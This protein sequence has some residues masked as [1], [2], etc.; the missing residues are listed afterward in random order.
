MSSK[1]LT[2]RQFI[3]LAGTTGAAVVLAACAPA[4]TATP[5]PPTAAPKAQPTQAPAATQVPAT[6][7][8]EPTKA[9]PT[10]A[11]AAAKAAELSYFYGGNPQKDVQLVA[12]AMSAYMKERINATIK[13]NTIEWAAFTEKMKLKDA[14]GELYDMCFTSGWANPY[15][16]AVR[17][18]V[19]TDLTELLPKLA[20][21]YYGGLNPGVWLA[22]KVKGKIYGAVNEQILP[23]AIGPICRQDL[24]EKYKLDL[25]K[26]TKPEDLE[27]W[28]E[29]IVAGEGGK[30]VPYW[31]GYNIWWTALFGLDDPGYGLVDYND[32]DLKVW[33]SWDHAQW[34]RAMSMTKKWFGKG[35]FPKEQPP[36]GECEQAIRAGKYGWLFHRAKPGGTFEMKT[37]RGLDMVQK[38]IENPTVLTTGNITSTMTAVNKKST[39]VEACVKYFELVN[40]D[41][42]FYNIL[43][44]GIEGK[45][46]VWTN[47]AKEV[48][49]FPEGVDG[50]SSGYNP[51]TDWEFG[52]QFNAYYVNENQVGSWEETRK[53]NNGSVASVLMGFVLDR[54]P[55]K[56]ELAAIAAASK[57]FS[58]MA[59]GIQDYDK[60]EPDRI[61]KL[62]AAGAEKVQAEIT[63][64]LQA[65]KA[66]A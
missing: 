23:G 1:N 33:H 7:A 21:K 9:Q 63:K 8:P 27:A 34:K 29:A 5:V 13:L 2:R 49:G 25:S 24:V 64:Q 50:K 66:G 52:N 47:K 48:V 4:P 30:V 3:A 38:I 65:W 22:P 61:A 42:V 46:W 15:I 19:Y 20:P 35:F 18:G 17:N 41:K 44:K 36:A 11:P 10:A 62:K 53:I 39:A 58:D 55:I 28:Q 40:T 16:D 59:F 12:D 26:V 14:A 32:K 37:Q 51:N 31:C 45:H 43:C 54:E 6:K 60:V 57:E 56:N